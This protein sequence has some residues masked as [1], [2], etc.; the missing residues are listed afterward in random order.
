MLFLKWKFPHLR[1]VKKRFLKLGMILS[2][3]TIAW[4][5][6]TASYFGM[7]FAPNNPLQKPSIIAYLAKK[8]AAYHLSLKDD[9][10]QGYVQKYPVLA[11][12]D[13]PE[14][15]LMQSKKGAENRVTYPV[16]EEFFNNILMEFSF[17][18]GI[19]HIALSFFRYLRRNFAGLG[20]VVFIVGGY[21]YFPSIVHATVLVN[22]MGWL[23]K[24][25]AYSIGFYMVL[26]GL[27][28]AFLAAFWQRKWGA[29]SEIFHVTQV[30]ADVLSYLRLYA[31]ALGGMVMARTFNDT[32]GM[33]MGVIGTIIIIFIGH[34]LNINM[35]LIGAV[36]HGLRL[37]FLEWFHYSFEG[38]GRLFN[39]LALKKLEK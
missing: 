18:M 28:F 29:F 14:T 19:I 35:S 27:S 13:N 8:K 31:L 25:I 32:L 2:I 22:F 36:V 5:F 26:G 16:F 24:P 6:F 17:L 12:Q 34:A 20:W 38:G 30:F 15:F 9:V 11:S 7:D 10:Y 39:P 21:L 33:E 1:R 37:N 23:S 3:A 4:G